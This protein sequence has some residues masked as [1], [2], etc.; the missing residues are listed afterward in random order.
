VGEDIKTLNLNTAISAMMIFVNDAQKAKKLNK[1][2]MRDF[3][4][5][6]A[7]FA[8]HLAE[9][10]WEK[11]GHKTSIHLEKWPEYDLAKIAEGQMLIVIQVNGRVRDK[12]T[13]AAD[14]SEDDLKKQ[15]LVSA[16]IKEILQGKTPEKV[17]VVPRKLVNI[18]LK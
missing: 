13:V 7:P 11:L 9:E 18:V 17:I 6:L 4:K 1:K 8:P 15:A 14:I 16:R 5:L 10:L 2:I 3:L 12:I